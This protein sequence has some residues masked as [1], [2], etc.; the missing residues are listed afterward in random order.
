MQ[1]EDYLAALRRDAAALAEVARLG[2]ADPVPSCPGWS[3][4]DLVVHTG[5]VHRA[6][7]HTVA[8]R[9]AE[10]QG[11]KREMFESV[12]SLLSWLESSTLMGGASDLEH[13]PPGMIEWFEEGA[14]I[15]VE[16]LAAAD[17]DD[18]VWSWSGNNR[19]AHYLRMMA[20]E[21][22]VHRWD[23][24]NAH[25]RARPVDHAL[26]LDGI[27]QTFEVMMPARRRWAEAPRGSGET[28]RFVATDAPAQWF[29]HF[30]GEPSVSRGGDQPADLTISGPANDLFL[31]LWQRV[32][33][34]QADGSEAL[35]DRYFELV[36]PA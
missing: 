22:A 35:I 12:P 20:I 33:P 15:L 19:V 27:S 21:T 8:I 31:S 23:A 24:E 18:P 32:G 30:D 1:K 13:I 11:I 2:L 16:T 28:F 25:G 36:P 9:A 10:P 26:A 3:V 6:Q 34:P 17:P 7:A 5:A 29:L 14:T 4:A